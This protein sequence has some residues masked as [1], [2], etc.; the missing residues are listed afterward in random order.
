MK[1]RVRICFCTSLLLALAGVAQA[2]NKEPFDEPAS[3]STCQSDVRRESSAARRTAGV[4]ASVL[5]GLLVHGTGHWVHGQPCV[6][7]R[8]AI[9]EAAGVGGILAGGSTIVFTGASRY[10]MLPAI[11]LTIAGF[12][13]FIT[14][15]AADLYG[16]S[17]AHRVAGEPERWRPRWETELG[18][19]RVDNPLFDFE[20]LVSQQLAANIGM[21]RFS[22]AL[23]TAL[24]ASHARYRMGA[25]LR[26]Y[27]P[28]TDMPSRDGSYFD[29]QAAVTE[30]RY[31]L[32]GFVTDSAELL[33]TGRLDLQRIGPTLRG[34]FAELSTGVA[35]AR[36]R[37]AINGLS[38]PVDLES[39]LLGR[40]AFG[41]YLGRG[42]HR[43]SEAMLYYDHRHD[44]YAAGL[45]MPGLGSGTLGHWGLAGR[46]YFSRQL[47]IGTELEI[48]SAYV[49]GLSLLFRDG[50]HR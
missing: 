15:F 10:L 39:L 25:T 22:G 28:R 49:T 1:R 16:T 34:A 29:L 21:L 3:K 20:W 30:Q 12:G 32:S 6:A 18:I 47:G 31:V 4:A 44:D 13:L 7:R 40:I 50:G 8:L 33:A 23:D 42:A 43:G 35:L 19:L 14:S 38:V 48:G 41:T 11:S 9:A 45:K 24:D 37:Y 2:K 5:P 26:S 27:G 17:G 46:Y 36:T